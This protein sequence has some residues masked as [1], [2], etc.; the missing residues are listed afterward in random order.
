VWFRNKT[1]YFK[2][3]VVPVSLLISAVGVYWAIERVVGG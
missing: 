3:V 2:G 1:W